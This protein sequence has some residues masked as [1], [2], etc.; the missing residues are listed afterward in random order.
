MDKKWVGNRKWQGP[1]SEGFYE[2]ECRIDERY[3]PTR[4]TIHVEAN[5][6]QEVVLD[7]PEPMKGS[8]SI[9]SN[10]LDADILIDGDL[11]GTTPKIVS[12]LMVGKHTVTLSH[13]NYQTEEREV[14]IVDGK[15]IELNVPLSDVTKM[16]ITSNPTGAVLWINRKYK[17]VT[18]YSEV[19]PSGDY[20]VVLLR[21]KYRDYA[22]QIHFDSSNPHLSIDMVRNYQLKT[23]FYIQPTFQIGSMMAYGGVLGVFI[24]NFNIEAS[25]LQGV[26]KETLYWINYGDEG[27]YSRDEEVS[28]SSVGVH[29]GRG[30]TFGNRFRLTPQIG[31]QTTLLNGISAF[32]S[33]YST[34]GYA[35]SASIGTRVDYALFS[36]LGVNLTP[37]FNFPI[38]K[39]DVMSAV[40]NVFPTIN[41]CVSG[42]KV[43]LGFYLIF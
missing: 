14:E 43:R 27:S 11:V 8:V 25:Y 37:E 7:A 32:A 36:C 35:F 22:K 16:T 30:I 17:G 10:P 15:T 6:A 31:V 13:A 42:V 29:F 1:L 41:G 2:V 12:N 23:C 34:K 26:D 21:K 19:L 3:R 9:F 38:N 39:S 24:H 40:T 28:I 33:S 18:P 20:D 4:T 5:K